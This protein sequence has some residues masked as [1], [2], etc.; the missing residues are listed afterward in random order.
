[1]GTVLIQITYYL[2]RQSWQIALLVVIIASAN[3]VL[4][5]RSA[6]VRYLLWLIVL[7]KCLVPPFYAVPL[8]IL[9]E[10][11]QPESAAMAPPVHVPSL[12]NET[13]SAQMAE[14]AELS[15]ISLEAHTSP[16]IE[17]GW[18]SISILEWLG[19]GWIVGAGA[20][21]M[22]N[23]LRA[24][25]ANLWLWRRRKTPPAELQKD[26]EDLFVGHG[27]KNLPK[28]WLVE[29][30]S[31]PF[32]WGLWR[33]SIY[34]PFDFLKINKPEHQRSV[35]SHELSHVL[36]FD[37]AINILQVI[38]QGIFWFHPLVWWANRK[39]RA[40]REKCCDEMAIARLNT[41]PSD[42]GTAILETLAAKHKQTRAVPSL[43]VAGPV[44]NIEER[45]KTM[46]RPGKKFYK[47]P[48][49]I[50]TTCVFLVTLLTV[51][52]T[53]VLT[54]STKREVSPQPRDQHWTN[55]LG[56]I[57]APVSETEVWF[58]IWE[59]RVRDFEAFIKA[60]GRDM[61]NKMYCL[62]SERE[63]HNWRNPGFAQ[64]PDHPVVGVNW[65]D[66]MAFC[67][68]LT[69]KER[70]EGVL[71]KGC[72]RLPSDLEWSAAVGLIHERGS[73]PEEQS[74]KQGVYPWGK[75][76]PPP[77]GAGN[78]ADMTARKKYKPDDLP[79]TIEG[80]DDGYAETSPVG[81]FNPNPYGLYDMGGNVL[82]WCGYWVS[83]DVDEYRPLRGASWFQ[84]DRKAKGNVSSLLSDYR[85]GIPLSRASSPDNRADCI[86]FRVVLD[87]PEN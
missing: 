22:F 60:T 63:G 48:S 24:L 78:Y 62:N 47:R 53:V 39:I 38:A 73:K 11:E 65:D 45:I 61:G 35:L 74:E 76:W 86:G 44:K 4:R 69:E 10:Q 80:Y 87:A 33:G 30:F 52:M 66:A 37:A 43:A 28:I 54:A 26:I 46:L 23:L 14:P 13:A 20:F 81:S 18:R 85:I 49:L 79:E 50:A 58:C 5:N 82:E 64:G 25:R 77:K 1:M 72:Y 67:K 7:A 3:I 12:E 16:I 84:G 34:L 29:G 51:P 71:L 2:L 55:S 41:L 31:Q 21:L 70:K 9:P 27:I 56:M 32:V 83:A 68:W 15:S 8:A 19:I 17:H 59:T 36:R 6:H 40:E 57:F 42:Y 75:Q